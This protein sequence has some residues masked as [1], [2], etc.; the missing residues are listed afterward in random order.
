[1]ETVGTK[2]IRGRCIE[3]PNGNVNHDGYVR[4]LPIPRAK[5]GRLVMRHRWEWE[6]LV[7]PIPDDYEINHL[8]KNRRCC[9]I[10]HLECI[11]GSEH[12]S[13]TNLQRYWHIRSKG[14]YLLKRGDSKKSVA[15]RLNRTIHTIN[16]WLR[17]E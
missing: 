17:E 3:P 16:R 13:K 5:G 11:H 1:M 7:G 4:I 8:C 10:D 15:E 12:A 9:N 6:R 14:L 2:P